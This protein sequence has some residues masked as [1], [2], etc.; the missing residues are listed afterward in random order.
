MQNRTRSFWMA[1]L[2]FAACHAFAQDQAFEGCVPPAEG[3][4]FTVTAAKANTQVKGV[5]M[6]RGARAVVFSNTAYNAPCD[7]LPV[8][9]ELVARG[10]QVALWRYTSPG[11][12]QIAELGE[13]VAEV[14]RRGATKVALVGGSRGGC[15]S[16]M[17]SSEL[18]APVAG[19][20]VLSC[21]AVFNR[22]SPT[23]TAPWAARLRAPVLH[24]T[25]ENDAIPTLDEAREEFKA[26]PVADKKLIIVPKTYAHGDQLLTAPDATAVARPAVLEF[27]ER[28]TR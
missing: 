16:M 17:A 1:A 4:P 20:V 12:E 18:Q 13:V 5:V 26:F 8:A 2:G 22:R 28:V 23:A 21:A 19:V 15:L 14:Q 7:W 25:G 27:V 10:F 9:R 11:L 3:T 6:G 24:I